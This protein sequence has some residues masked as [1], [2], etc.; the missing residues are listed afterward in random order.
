[1]TCSAVHSHLLCILLTTY[2]ILVF[3]TWSSNEHL[4]KRLE[5]NTSMFEGN[6]VK[7]GGT[8]T[9]TGEIQGTDVEII[10]VSTEVFELSS[11][12]LFFIFRMAQQQPI[13]K[14]K[15]EKNSNEKSEGHKKSLKKNSP[16]VKDGIE[17]GSKERNRDY[18]YHKSVSVK[19]STK[20]KS[21]SS[22][23]EPEEKKLRCEHNS[24]I[25]EKYEHCPTQSDRKS[26]NK[27]GGNER[28][29][30]GDAMTSVRLV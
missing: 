19:K 28:K 22:K 13:D 3:F 20:N 9:T 7:F 26:E 23:K 21:I 5:Q 18:K 10:R 24:R 8:E 1:M 17:D 27:I 14:F 4:F 11:S 6:I 29:D 12:S 2:I 30:T 15:P 16:E 25:S